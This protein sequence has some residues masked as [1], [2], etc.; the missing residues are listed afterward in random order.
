MW[1]KD[2]KLRQLNSSNEFAVQ[3]AQTKRATE[4]AEAA[5]ANAAKAIKDTAIAYD[6]LNAAEERAHK[7]EQ[8]FDNLVAKGTNGW[9]DDMERLL[10]ERGKQ[11]EAQ[12][13]SLNEKLAVAEIHIRGFCAENCRC[14]YC[15]PRPDCRPCSARAI[16]LEISAT[17]G[18]SPS[19]VAKPGAGEGK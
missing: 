2:A 19:P 16:L 11:Y 3:H 1:E 18:S 15:K 7:A 13:A 8:R 9:Y 17:G 6:K 12:V 14:D 10:S 5:E 4:R